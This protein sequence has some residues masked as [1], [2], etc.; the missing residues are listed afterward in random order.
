MFTKK[1]P[2]E[3]QNIRNVI[4]VKLGSSIVKGLISGN[5]VALFSQGDNITLNRGQELQVVLKSDLNIN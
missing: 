3:M 4:S 1:K 5:L 2:K